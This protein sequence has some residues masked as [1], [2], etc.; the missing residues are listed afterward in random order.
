MLLMHQS[1][2]PDCLPAALRQWDA[3]RYQEPGQPLKAAGGGVPLLASPS[4]GMN[5]LS[6]DERHVVVQDI[7]GPLIRDL[8]KNGFTPIPVRWRHGRSLGG[9]FHCVTLDIR[10]DSS[11]DSGF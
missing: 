5:V 4:I 3:I 2:D 11:P 7:Q 9:G 6:L 10:R 8:E 1:V